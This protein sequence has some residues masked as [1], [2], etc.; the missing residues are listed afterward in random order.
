M[1][2]NALSRTQPHATPSGL[3][4]ASPARLTAW[5]RNA[6]LDHLLRLGDDDRRMRF[7]QMATD[8]TIA[9][10]VSK[11][12]FAESACFGSFDRERRLVALTEGLPYRAS[13]ARCIEAAFST[14]KEWRHHGLARLGF[15]ALQVCC[16][17]SGVEHVVLHCDARNAPMRGLLRAVD[18]T[19]QV[20]GV[21]IDAS[22]DVPNA[23]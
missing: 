18:A 19:V 23:A 7:Q 1:N 21:E 6:V 17:V 3:L 9:A 20:D 11:I 15:D 13:G 16:S 22:V 2:T 12:D 14:D 8:S 10:Y 4:N 5:H